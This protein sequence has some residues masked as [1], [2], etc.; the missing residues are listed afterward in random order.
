MLTRDVVA[1]SAATPF[2]ER[3]RGAPR[4]EFDPPIKAQMMAIDG[5]WARDCSVIDMS[6][7]GAQLEC[8]GSLAGV[9]EFFLMLSS[10]VRPVYRRCKAVWFNG[11]RMGVE[12][13]R[14][15]TSK[16]NH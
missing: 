3:R 6:E 16:S 5:T 13:Q 14:R 4:V 2:M 8:E 7:T 9:S 12:L 15:G 11:H 10:S 1:K